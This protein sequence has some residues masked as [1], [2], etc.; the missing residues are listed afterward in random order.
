MV[1][2]SWTFFVL[3]EFIFGDIHKKQGRSSSS[4]GYEIEKICGWKMYSRTHENSELYWKTQL[5]LKLFTYQV[6]SY[7]NAAL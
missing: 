7:G 5:L 6:Q 2:R 4:S 3:R 1:S